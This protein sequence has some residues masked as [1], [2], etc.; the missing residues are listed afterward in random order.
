MAEQTVASTEF[1][2]RA[3]KYIDE[4]GKDPVFITRHSRPVR[5]LLDIEEYQRLKKLDE[6]MTD[7]M[8]EERI[9]VHRDT[10]LKLAK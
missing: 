1:Q 6:E 5:V 4:S 9:A 2:T 3:G 7:K 10:L 8:M